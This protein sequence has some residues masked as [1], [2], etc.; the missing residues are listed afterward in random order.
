MKI[1]KELIIIIG[2]FLAGELIAGYLSVPF[3]GSVLGM[4]ALV[5][6]MFLKVFK[7]SDL[8][9]LTGFFDENMSLFFIP[10][11]VE[12][13]KIFDIVRDNLWQILVI[14][15]VT[16]IL[17]FMATYFSAALL[18]KLFYNEK[19]KEGENNADIA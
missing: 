19:D 14:I 9:Q 7:E 12:I 8:E 1:F 2:I 3:F 10:P 6:L 11:A 16:T 15:F 17:T 4:F 18:M 5:T 13:I